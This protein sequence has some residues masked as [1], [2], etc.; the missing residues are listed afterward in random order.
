MKLVLY[1]FGGSAMVLAGIIA[2]YVAAGAH[3]SSL[4]D[5]AAFV[6]PEQFQFWIFP[7]V[8]FGFAILAGIWPMHTW[9]PTGH[10]AAPTAAS[11]LL[12]GV[13]MKLGAY[14]CVRVAMSLFPQGLA[15]WHQTIGVLAVIG[16]LW[17]AI[18]ALV[19]NDF[20][21]VIG[22]SSV[23]HMGLVL[24]GFATLSEIGFAG[25]I[26]QTFSHGIIAGLLFAVV[27]RMI[28]DR[29]HTRDMQLLHQSSLSKLLPF[30]AV[31]FAI[32]A[33]ASMGMPG[34]SGFIAEIQV[35][36]GAWN[37]SPGWAI[38]GGVGILLAVAYLLRAL[39]LS[40]FGTPVEAE[41]AEAAHFTQLSP[42]TIPERLGA[43]GLVAIAIIAGVFPG[44]LLEK[45]SAG[46][47]GPF[48]NGLR[49][50]SLWKG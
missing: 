6:F 48:F 33:F 16:I 7:L 46:L 37:V 23:S 39:Q 8:F 18:V 19:Q 36:T 30:A 25:A 4:V 24:L 2:A 10:V 14:G 13:V 43:V 40:F 1:S 11:M 28:Y 27:G 49:A 26:F 47:N 5:L 45:I 9:A 42:I 44:L 15:A 31:I 21:F 50:V 41:G 17:G 34:F 12:A 22:Y 29:T 20:K 38:A 35:L 32:A 3:T